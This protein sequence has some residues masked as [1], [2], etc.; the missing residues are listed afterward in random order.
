MERCEKIFQELEE[1]QAEAKR[2]GRGEKGS[3][4]IGCED[5][6]T[7]GVLTPVLQT[8]KERYPGIS[9]SVATQPGSDL[10]KSD[11]KH[12]GPKLSPSSPRDGSLRGAY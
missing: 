7:F 9:R 8:F 3:L 11:A 1:A 12:R 4:R 10:E 6:T 5:G 2:Y